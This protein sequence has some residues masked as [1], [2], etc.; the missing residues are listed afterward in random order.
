[1]ELEPDDSFIHNNIGR[2][3]EDLGE[4]D[5]A[6]ESFDTAVALD[7]TNAVA[8]N[9]F[10]VLLR[11]KGFTKE[12]E[13]AFRIAI[14]VAPYCAN[15]WLNLKDLSLA[16]HLPPRTASQYQRRLP[17]P[18]ASKWTE[19]GW[20]VY[21]EDHLSKQIVRVTREAMP[22][23]VVGL[24]EL[25]LGLFNARHYQDCYQLLAGRIDQHPKDASLWN[26]MGMTSEK[27]G[28][29]EQAA[30]CYKKCIACDSSYLSAI[31]NLQEVQFHR[32]RFGTDSENTRQHI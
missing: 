9:N 8:W 23:S 4:E 31:Y 12:A 30:A 5:D 10:G 28:D 6:L 24:H 32:P 29:L 17:L 19:A 7:R 26:L 15:P 14:S 20:N 25:A 16:E 2:L 1:M 22:Q 27:L 13:K 18:V 3:L 21:D 11:K